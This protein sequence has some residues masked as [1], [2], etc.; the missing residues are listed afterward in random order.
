MENNI[1]IKNNRQVLNSDAVLSALE[2]SLAMI[3]FNLNKEVI[4]VN[5]NFANTL[6]YTV[7]EM[8]NMSHKQ[9]CTTEFVYS[10]GYQE[11]WDSLHKGF[12]F[13]EKI[14][15]L[16]KR[17]NL[18]WLEAT[19]IPIFNEEG[20]VEGVLK[21]ATDITERENRTGDIITKLKE[22]PEELVELVVTNSI[23]Q[24]DA[25]QS[26]KSQTELIREV[27]KLI[28]NISAQTNML[29]INAAIE[30]AHAGVHGRGFK[31]VADEVRKLAG[32][33][34]ESINQVNNNVDHIIFEVT[35]VGDITENLQKSVKETKSRFEKTISEFEGVAVN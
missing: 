18:L 16:G 15:R 12:K 20:K 4:W 3:E 33:V 28:R 29:A 25:L 2:T 19:Y 5:D 6:G 27:S 22:M 11:F 13:Q 7:D 9:F 26:L 31:V 10:R 32:N 1:N 35:K 24:I 30:A 17:G 14:Q 34:S 23:E 21:M 8:I